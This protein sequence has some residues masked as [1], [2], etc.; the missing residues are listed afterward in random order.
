MIWTLNDKR[1]KENRK[2]VAQKIE[3][4]QG[5]LAEYLFEDIGKKIS[6]DGTIQQ[7]FKDTLHVREQV[8]KR[9]MQFYF[10]GYWGK[11]NINILCFDRTGMPFDTVRT[12]FSLDLLERKIPE[13][14]NK[15]ESP[16]LYF[17]SNASEQQEYISIIPVRES[18]KSETVI[19]SIVVLLTPKLF[20][21]DEGFPELFVSRKVAFNKELAKYSY[22]RYR[23]DSLL[24]QSGAFAYYFSSKIFH[25]SS[26]EYSFVDLDNYNHLI[27]RLNDSSFIIVS[28][29]K[30]SQLLLFT[31]FSYLFSFFSL[32]LLT[33]YLLW[34]MINRELRYQLNLTQRIQ[35]SVMLLVILSFILIGSGTVYYITKKYDLNKDESIRDK[36][37]SLLAVIEKEMGDSPRLNTR[38]SDES[39]ASLIKLSGMLDADFNLFTLDGNL[40]YSSQPKIFEQGIISQKMNPEV[41]FEMSEKGKTQFVHP[42]S[43]GKLNYIS[44]YEPL[45]NRQGKMIGYLHLP[46]FEKQNELNNEI[47]NFLS[48]LINIYILLLALAVIITLIISSRITQPLLLIQE[49]LSNIRLGRKNEPIEYRRK[50]EIGELVN[51]YNRMI[52]ELAAS[53]EK[54]S[55]SERESAWREMAKQVA[56]EIK[57]PLTPM[58]LSVQHLQK[59]WE[60]KS[61]KLTEI[62]QRISQT[63]VEQ[64]DTLSNIA[65]EFST[66]AQM[67]QAKKEPVDLNKIIG[68]L[69]DL[70][71]ELP[72]ISVTFSGD[73]KEKIVFAD[74]DQLS[75]MFSNLLKNATQAIQSDK[76]GIIEVA[77]V[78]EN[79]NY[80]ISV[81]DNG[82]GIPANQ[83]ERIFTPSF[84]TKSSGMGLGLSIVKSIVEGSGGT[85]RFETQEGE[86][87]TFFVT[88][89]AYQK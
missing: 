87:T 78:T 84:T 25:P 30:E 2:L 5:Q 35:T 44:A 29:S 36:I 15:N 62:F 41:L 51:E 64:I 16:R 13:E 14:E 83:I 42:E 43:I 20:Q 4:G 9:L 11:F 27:H 76:N 54:L 53:A 70:F 26:E 63:L 61:P 82:A 89:P 65:T 55:R 19:G 73:Q 33:F 12:K 72:D 81:H 80:I 31:L 66:F 46:Y 47:S 79:N 1:E 21:S 85:I 49:K 22:A 24:N 39:Q 69:L 28:K 3:T 75:R 56:H 34:R 40:C 50:D 86:G 60:E 71:K 48:A 8:S 23:N 18:K 10:S 59:A 38:L 67:P 7:H 17:L 77:V 32:L 74:K 88:L 37:N 52:E 68:S 57:N 45:R 58:K 6:N